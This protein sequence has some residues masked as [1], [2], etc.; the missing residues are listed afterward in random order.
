[1]ARPHDGLDAI[2]KQRLSASFTEAAA[3]ANSHIELVR[4][5]SFTSGES[6]TAFARFA[7]RHRCL[8]ALLLY[9]EVEQYKT[10]FSGRTR[11]ARRLFRLYVQEGASWEVSLPR[12]IALQVERELEAAEKGTG[13]TDDE[14]FDAAQTEVY[15][16]MRLDIFPRYCEAAQEGLRNASGEGA[17][18]ESIEVILAGTHL[19]ASRS[20]NEFVREHFCEEALLFWLEANAFALLLDERD[21]ASRSGFIYGSFL[22][23]DAPYSINI[24]EPVRSTIQ[25]RIERGHVDNDIFTS[26]QK[27]V[28]LELELDI[29]PRY[30]VWA[31]EQQRNCAPLPAMGREKRE[32]A[33]GSQAARP[34]SLA[35]GLADAG[36]NDRERA[37][38]NVRQLL[39]IP[40]ELSLLREIAEASHA[41]ENVDFYVDVQAFKLLFEP[42]Q[43]KKV[44]RELWQRYIDDDA[45]CVITLP[46]EVKRQLEADA[47]GDE[48]HATAFDRAER[49]TLAL[50]TDNLYLTYQQ[51]VR[52]R[53]GGSGG[54]AP[55]ASPSKVSKRAVGS[56]QPP[57]R[58]DGCVACSTQ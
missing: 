54:A 19:A 39:A 37:R 17:I 26:A 38:E 10:L 5:T 23:A 58:L 49:E 32:Q 52:Q 1:M 4:R 20:F 22:E 18:A 36:G 8:E 12:Q 14:L 34:V 25:R 31:R 28:E 16:Q 24:S 13:E 11:A 33:P 51:R 3:N 53:E 7:H 29:F 35:D 9:K 57:G 50:I 56:Q 42:R 30:I 2:L 48:V 21:L 6:I 55:A 46:D 40:E 47:L 45:V 15:E 41:I 27:E 43:R 44:A